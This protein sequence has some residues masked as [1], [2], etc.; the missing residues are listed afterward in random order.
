MNHQL[1]KIKGKVAKIKT[2]QRTEDMTILWHVLFWQLRQEQHEGWEPE[3]C[4][5][6]SLPGAAHPGREAGHILCAAPGHEPDHG[7]GEP[8]HHPAHQAGPSPPHA[9]L[10]L[11]HHLAL[12][13]VSLS[14][15]M[16]PQMLMNM[17]A[18]LQSIPYSGDVFFLTLWVSWQFSSHSDGLWQVCNH[19]SASLVHRCHEAGTVCLLSS[20]V[21]VPLLYPCPVT[22]PPFGPTVLPCW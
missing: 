2:F 13:D 9:H 3:Q 5:Q 17:K 20:C 19:L 1:R 7:A 18:W 11:H 6:V 4:V 21:L 15:I 8:A 12:K 10:F 22:H 16:F 14:S